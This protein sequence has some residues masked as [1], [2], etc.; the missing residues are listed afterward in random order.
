MGEILG[1]GGDI[2]VGSFFGAVSVSRE[3]WTDVPEPLAKSIDPEGRHPFGGSMTMM[4]YSRRCRPRLTLSA[5]R[6]LAIDLF[7][8]RLTN[9][10][11][12]GPS[13]CLHRAS[14]A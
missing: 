8:Q 4:G 12:P 14:L 11:Q 6:P 2:G 9:R 13:Q 7:V 1:S 3:V 10:V 5:A